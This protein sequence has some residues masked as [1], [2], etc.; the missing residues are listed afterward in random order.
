ML[1]AISACSARAQLDT[2]VRS[3]GPFFSKTGAGSREQAMIQDSSG[4]EHRKE[5]VDRIVIKNNGF[6][7]QPFAVAQ[8]YGLVIAGRI[9]LVFVEDGWTRCR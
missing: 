7:P 2:A 9:R 4:A 6:I 5:D 3:P 8:D 1:L